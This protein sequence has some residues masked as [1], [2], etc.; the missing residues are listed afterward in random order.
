M[1]ASGIVEAE[2]ASNARAGVGHG[3]IGLEVDF[4]VLDRAPDPLNEDIVPPSALAFH[5]HG[6]LSLLQ[7]IREVH[8]GELGT[9]IRV[10][11][12]GLAMTGKHSR[13][14]TGVASLPSEGL[15]N[16]ELVVAL[17]SAFRHPEKHII[18]DIAADRLADLASERQAAPWSPS[19]PRAKADIERCSASLAK[20]TSPRK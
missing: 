8:G 20:A 15:L 9:L 11:H 5:E 19:R 10:E 17:T 14:A 2:T 18:D 7:C 3:L 12:V 16:I 13:S 1:R 4:R 6:D